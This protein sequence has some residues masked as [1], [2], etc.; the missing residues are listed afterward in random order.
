[1]RGHRRL[2][3][4]TEVREVGQKL[5]DD[6]LLAIDVH[7]R[8]DRRAARRQRSDER[9]DASALALGRAREPM[10]HHQSSSCG[11]VGQITVHAARSDALTQFVFCVELVRSHRH[12]MSLRVVSR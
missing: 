10:H 3:P 4:V 1:V 2:E 7:V 11:H 5:G 6:H 8:E 9:V 12:D